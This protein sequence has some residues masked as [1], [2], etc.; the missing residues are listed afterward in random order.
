MLLFSLPSKDHLLT[1]QIDQH[2]VFLVQAHTDNAIG[3][4]SPNMGFYV[5]GLNAKRNGKSF[6]SDFY[7]ASIIYNTQVLNFALFPPT[8]SRIVY[9]HTLLYGHKQIF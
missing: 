1:G 6:F 5:C 8:F 9:R 3:A 7:R 2:L 4:N